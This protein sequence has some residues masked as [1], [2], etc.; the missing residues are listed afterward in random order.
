MTWVRIVAALRRFWWAI[1][2]VAASALALMFRVQRD[3][4]RHTL[5]NERAAW[6]AE[7]D[8]AD[9]AR[10]TAERDYA[11]RLATAADGYAARISA[12]KPIILRSTDT[13]REYA[14][15][16]AG[17]AVC[18]GADRVR[19]ID[20]LDAEL[21]DDPDPARGG[22]RAVQADARPPAGGR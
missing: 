10:L 22:A 16:A 5:D 11:V 15:T 18:L 20:A 6:T 17:R 21:A 12:L 1:P 2:I 9:K 4:A 13:V 19:G 8:R 7:I 3:D 14:Q